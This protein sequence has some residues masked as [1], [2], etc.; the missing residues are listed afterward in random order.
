MPACGRNNYPQRLASI[1]KRVWCSVRAGRERACSS[2]ALFP[3][4][5]GRRAKI[6]ASIR[7]NDRAPAAVCAAAGPKRF[8]CCERRLQP[9]KPLPS[10]VL[11]EASGSAGRV[12]W[13]DG[14]NT[15]D[16]LV[17][18]VPAGI[19]TAVGYRFFPRPNYHRICA[20]RFCP[21][22]LKA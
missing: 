16:T 6:G 1:W 22:N 10:D 18:N 2:R 11:W 9:S 15:L 21:H 17:I 7:V 14:C 20:S 3:S 19:P 5:E 13:P 8:R 12:L 4:R